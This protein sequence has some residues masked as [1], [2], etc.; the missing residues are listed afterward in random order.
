MMWPRHRMYMYMGLQFAR[1][2]W[3]QWL[4]A[5]VQAWRQVTVRHALPAYVP[6]K[7]TGH[8]LTVGEPVG[9]EQEEEHE[10]EHEEE[11]HEEGEF[12]NEE[13]ADRRTLDARR[14]PDAKPKRKRK[15]LVDGEW[16]DRLPFNANGPFSPSTWW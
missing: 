10:E 12:L 2:I 16:V 15:H 4:Q 1:R 13:A 14:T 7:Y 9:Q 8:I 6:Y 5:Q 3:K 11:E